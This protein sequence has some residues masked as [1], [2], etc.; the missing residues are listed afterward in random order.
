MQVE[1]AGHARCLDA[2]DVHPG[3]LRKNLEY[4]EERYADIVEGDPAKQMTFARSCLEA[5]P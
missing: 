3:V 5:A 4:G 2:H 1:R